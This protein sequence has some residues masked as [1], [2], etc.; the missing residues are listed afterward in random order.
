MAVSRRSPQEW[1][2]APFSWS[3]ICTWKNWGLQFSDLVFG[4]HFLED[5]WAE[6]WGKQLT[7]FVA[8]DKI[9]A[10]NQRVEFWKAYICHCELNAFPVIKD[11]WG[12]GCWCYRRVVCTLMKCVDTWLCRRPWTRVFQ[13]TST[14]WG[15]RC[16]HSASRPV[17]YHVRKCGK[18]LDTVQ[19]P[20]CN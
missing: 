9:W 4:R 2:P 18:F 12:D 19:I 8:N 14:C 6:S 1:S 10:F 11:V 5:E 17:D 7:V 16:I 13:V 20:C 3:T 15:E